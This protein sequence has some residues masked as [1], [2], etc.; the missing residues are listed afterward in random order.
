MRSL[1]LCLAVAALLL[2]GGALPT[3]ALS[4]AGPATTALDPVQGFWHYAIQQAGEPTRVRRWLL[5]CGGAVLCL[6]SSCGPRD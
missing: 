3:E 1:H 5:A 2:G 6:L 4:A